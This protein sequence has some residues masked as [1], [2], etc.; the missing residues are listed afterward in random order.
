[1]AAVRGT[2]SDERR[3][4]AGFVDAFLEDLALLVF[5]VEHHLVFIDWLVELA[6]RRVDAQLAEHAFHTEG[7][8]F[9]RDDRDDALADFLVLDQLRQN[10]H[11]GHGGGDFAVARAVQDRFQRFQWRGRHA[12]ALGTALRYEATQGCAALGQ[13][14]G[15]GRTFFRLEERQVL[16][17]GILDRDVEAVTEVT[18][19]VDVDLLGVVRG[20]LGFAGTGT[21]TL[22]GLGQDDGR[23]VL[24]VDRLV[25]RRVDLVRV[26]AA[27]VEL[28][29]LFVGQ[30]FDHGLELWG[31]EEVLTNVRA[32]FGFVVLVLAVDD[33]VHAALQ[34][35]VGVLGQQWV[36][37]T[38]PDDFV[39]VPAT[40]TEHAFEFL[41][42]LAV[43]ANRAVEALQVAVDDEDQVVQL[44]AASQGDRAQG[45][46]LVA[47]A[48]AHE[49][50]DL[51]LAGRD[52]ATGF[53]VLHE[54]CLVDR[55]DRAQTHRYGRELPEV[56]H[57]PWVRVRRQ[58]VAVHFLTEVVH[59][60]FVDA[61]F[62]ERTGVD[63]WRS[64]ALE[65]DQVA[66]VFF[67]RGLEEVVEADVVQGGAGGEAGDVS[68]QVRV[69]QV[70][71][72]DHGQGVP[73]YQ[74]ANAAFHEQ[75]A[76][77]ACFVGDRDGVAVWRGDRIRQLGATT[78]G[79]LAHT[80]HQVMSAVF[81]FFVEDRLQ[82]IQPFLGFDWIEVLHGLL[83]G[84]KATRIDCL[85]LRL[86]LWADVVNSWITGV[87]SGAV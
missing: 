80:G 20:V 14:L 75:V 8:G 30:V 9:V 34:G 11:E 41:D 86:A 7:T 87:S 70:G 77:H 81:A 18:Q 40:A 56:R 6:D 46:R 49:A 62:H 28:P 24:V 44:L 13:V 63:T 54:A 50:P 27:T 2:G 47:L 45:F 83:Q 69:F 61:A 78:G 31:V 71:A 36:P 67:G 74:R 5:A 59:L 84:G 43:A 72:H 85:R 57:Q 19:A 68:A 26:V 76:R 22:D 60:V 38:A 17:V 82:G 12:E 73:T 51:L 35:T 64:V 79:Q 16:Q 48:V 29:D 58:A 25:V 4:G 32:V 65:E 37:E 23:L 15:F 39:D 55:L 66:A 3:H 1:M 42:D 33:F 53:Q 21:V 52:E 10:T